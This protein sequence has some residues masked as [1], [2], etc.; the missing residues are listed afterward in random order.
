[1]EESSDESVGGRPRAL[2]NF[3]LA[4]SHRACIIQAGVE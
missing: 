4:M 1:M 3:S 2:C